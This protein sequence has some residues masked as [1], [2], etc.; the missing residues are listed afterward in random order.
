MYLVNNGRT[1]AIALG[2]LTLMI[3][4]AL[5]YFVNRY[6]NYFDLYAF[7][8]GWGILNIFGGK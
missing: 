3:V 1:K 4:G 8:K 2:V 7:N 6:G 5:V